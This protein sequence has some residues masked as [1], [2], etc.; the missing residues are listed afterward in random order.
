MAA[1]YK[2]TKL[3]SNR[4]FAMMAT[5]GVLSLLSV[6]VISVFANAMASFRSGM[7]DLEK[8]RTYFAAEA[9]AESAMAQLAAILEVG[10]R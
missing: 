1:R 8:S 9:A 3:G 4:G 6:L 2:V 7:T 5:L 10:G